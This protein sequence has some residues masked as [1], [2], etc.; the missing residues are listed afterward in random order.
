MAEP[1]KF[2]PERVA[3]FEATGWRAYYDRQWLKLLRL[4]VQLCQEQFHIPFP[5]SL[6]AAYYVTRASAAWA[7]VD[8]D[9]K[10]VLAYYIQFYRM[11]RRYSGLHFDPVRAG[12]LELKYNDVHRQ[13]VGQPDKTAFI[14]TM[15]QLHSTLFGITPQQARESAELRVLANNTVDL[16]TGRTSTDVEGDWRKL[17]EY[18]RQCYRSIQRESQAASAPAA[19][20]AAR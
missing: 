14:E 17:E 4:V 20:S 3:Y 15:V 8:H 16:I 2:N 7:P 13:L 9:A 6:Q 12:L 18:L 1:F 5:R 19:V 10:V 11:A